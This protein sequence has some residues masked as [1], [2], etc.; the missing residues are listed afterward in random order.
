MY[1]VVLRHLPTMACGNESGAY[2]PGVGDHMSRMCV[3][4]V[5]LIPLLLVRHYGRSPDGKLDPD[6]DCQDPFPVVL[7]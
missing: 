3:L 7:F 1:G 5:L 4:V 2:L 6:V